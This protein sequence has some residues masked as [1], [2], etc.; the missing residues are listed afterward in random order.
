LRRDQ[1]LL[2]VFDFLLVHVQPCLPPN[3]LDQFNFMRHSANCQAY[4]VLT[5]QLSLGGLLELECIATGKA[6]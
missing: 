6:N 3:E 1:A 5:I 2:V 4:A